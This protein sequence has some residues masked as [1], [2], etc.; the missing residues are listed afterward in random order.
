MGGH[1][2]GDV[3]S[4]MA[5][6]LLSDAWKE[7]TAL[8]TAEEIETWLQKQFKKSIKKLFFIRKVKWI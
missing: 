1:R 3:A 5:V 4:E 7:T 6:R 2:A 8:L